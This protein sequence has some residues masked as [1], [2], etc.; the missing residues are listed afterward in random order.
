MRTRTQHTY[1]YIPYIHTY[2][3][4]RARAYAYIRTHTRYSQPVK[5]LVGSWRVET[6]LP[7]ADMSTVSGCPL[8]A[9]VLSWAQVAT[10]AERKAAELWS[11]LRLHPCP[12]SRICLRLHAVIFRLGD[13]ILYVMSVKISVFCV[14]LHVYQTTR[15]N[16]LE[17]NLVLCMFSPFVLD[18]FCPHVYVCSS[19]LRCSQHFCF[20]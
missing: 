3:H 6:Q 17:D 13:K 18:F 2:I 5:W 4:A 8:Q 7:I 10:S 15:R 1:T 20:C 14:L 11:L 12:R 19:V 16:I 9:S